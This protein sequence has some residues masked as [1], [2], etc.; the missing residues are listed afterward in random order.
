MDDFLFY[1]NHFHEKKHAPSRGRIAVSACALG[2]W[3]QVNAGP[4]G[5]WYARIRGKCVQENLL[6]VQ[7]IERECGTGNWCF[8][9]RRVDAIDINTVFEVSKDMF[10]SSASAS[11]KHSFTCISS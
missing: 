9:S 2:E 4:E 6:K 5:L 10:H 8:K 7:W 1:V 3:V 11:G